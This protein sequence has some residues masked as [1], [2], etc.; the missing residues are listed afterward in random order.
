MQQDVLFL[1]AQRHLG[2]LRRIDHGVK[3]LRLLAQRG[4]ACRCGMRGSCFQLL[5][6][7]KII[8]RGGAAQ[9]YSTLRGNLKGD[10][11]D[12]TTMGTPSRFFCAATWNA[13]AVWV[14]HR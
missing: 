9:C 11:V 12:S 8:F 3:A 7:F 13:T 6:C 2:D 5:H 4:K 1:I 10:A 14:S